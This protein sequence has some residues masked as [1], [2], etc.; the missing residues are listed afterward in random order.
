MRSGLT[1]VEMIIALSLF[2]ISAIFMGS[3]YTSSTLLSSQARA[4]QTANAIILREFAE[5]RRIEQEVYTANPDHEGI[6]AVIL[7]VFTNDEIRATE[8]PS[9]D[10]STVLGRI[11]VWADLDGDGTTGRLVDPDNDGD[12]RE[13]ASGL[14]EMVLDDGVYVYDHDSDEDTNRISLPRIELRIVLLWRSLDGEAQ[15]TEQTFTMSRKFSG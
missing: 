15:E 3:L 12:Y 13:E 11:E 4:Q 14:G 6:D 2:I 1:L 8:L 5:L 9:Q 7:D 10:G